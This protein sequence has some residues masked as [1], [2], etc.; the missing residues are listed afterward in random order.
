MRGLKTTAIGL[1]LL[2]G[3]VTAWAEVIDFNSFAHSDAVR[4]EGLLPT[5]QI[6]DYQILS[7]F[8]F[9]GGDNIG[10]WSRHDPNQADYGNA[11]LLLNHSKTIEVS[12]IDGLSFNL[13]SFDLAPDVWGNTLLAKLDLAYIDGSAETEYL[14]YDISNYSNR[15]FLETFV[16]NKVGIKS[17]RLNGNLQVDNIVLSNPT[18]VP[19]PEAYSMLFMGLLGISLLGRFVKQ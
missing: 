12:R 19:E 18:T 10:T 15:S 5:L 13:N 8:G 9:C 16:L 3:S 11:S 4:V 14:N 17:F 2:L 1:S 7:C 6:G